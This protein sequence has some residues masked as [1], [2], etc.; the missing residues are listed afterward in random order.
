M[1]YNHDRAVGCMIGFNTIIKAVRY[2]EEHDHID[3]RAS[4]HVR[5]VLK[6]IY[7][8]ELYSYYRHRRPRLRLAR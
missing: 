3:P 6:V 2:V 1:A 5:R 8:R 7:G 4:Q